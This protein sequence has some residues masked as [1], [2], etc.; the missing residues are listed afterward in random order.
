MRAGGLTGLERHGRPVH[1]NRMG[2]GGRGA[3]PGLR[4]AREHRAQRRRR[5]PQD[6]AGI[7]PREPRSGN[8]LRVVR[9]QS[10]HEASSREVRDGGGGNRQHHGVTQVD[11]RDAR[12]DD[13]P[14]RARG[15]SRNG[16]HGVV[17]EHP[18]DHEHA[19]EPALLGQDGQVHR[20]ARP[21]RESP[22]GQSHSHRSAAPVFA[23]ARPRRTA[24]MR[25][26]SLIAIW[27]PRC[28]ASAATAAR[29]R[30][31]L[32]R[33]ATAFYTTPRGERRPRPI[34]HRGE[35]R[36]ASGSNAARTP[37]RCRAP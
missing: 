18:L 5:L 8:H 16:R 37:L 26:T 36:P 15:H 20:R 30:S 23:L 29:R 34:S 24:V 21:D 14:R 7:A 13:D 32:P 22:Q 11:I 6:L 1:R 28:R 31:P 25:P 27:S 3:Q 4:L 17:A 35:T 10:E 12:S 9:A 2:D 33:P 19:V